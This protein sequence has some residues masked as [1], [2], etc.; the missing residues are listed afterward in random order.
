[1]NEDVRYDEVED[2]IAAA[3]TAGAEVYKRGRR[4]V[5]TH[6][7]AL[8]YLQGGPGERRWALMSRVAAPVTTV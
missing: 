6:E 5:A 8:F 2:G 4:V 3:H 1:M 7:G